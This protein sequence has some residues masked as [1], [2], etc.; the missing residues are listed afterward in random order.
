MTDRILDST[1]A[2]GP[3]GP[4][5]DRRELLRGAGLAFPAL[6]LGRARTR[7]GRPN[8]LVVTSDQQHWQALGAVDPFFETP[9]LDAFGAGAL[10][11]ANA[12]CTS[13]QC[14]PSRASL[15]TGAFPHLTGVDTN[16]DPREKRLALPTVGARLRA[17][18]YRTVYY[19]KWHLGRVAPDLAGFDERREAQDDEVTRSAQQ[20]LRSWRGGGRPFALFLMYR[21]PH[22]IQRV[23]LEGPIHRGEREGEGEREVPLDETWEREDFEGKPPVHARF[24][25]W[26]KGRA[27]LGRSRE[28]W[29]AFRLE[30]RARVAELDERVG[31]VLRVL[32]RRGL[33]ASTAVLFTSDH[34]EMETRHRLVFKGPLMYEHLVRVPLLARLPEAFGGGRAG[35]DQGFAWQ[36]VDLAP[37][38]LELAGAPVE[39]GAE[40]ALA[41]GRSIVPLLRGEALPERS[42]VVAQFLSKGPWR[43]PVRMLRTRGHKYVRYVEHG[44]ELYDLERDPGELANRADD[45]ELAGVRAELSGALDRWMKNQADPFP[46]LTA[47]PL[48]VPGEADEGADE[49]DG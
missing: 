17:A 27:L 24:Q 42:Y 39:P 1:T 6:A 37:T 38:L 49:G 29:E 30:Y 46:G 36:H 15:M 45:P 12:F 9:A 23:S 16:L 41:P 43:C 47:S 7:D 21:E 44:E 13:P 18:G 3:A 8:L 28:A 33:D 48:P 25:A 14:S 10:R 26:S 2:R 32:A 31:E 4:G 35:V 5:P 40:G 22:G 19:G 20:F 11:F 34:G